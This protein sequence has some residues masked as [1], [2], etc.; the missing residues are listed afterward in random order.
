LKRRASALI[1]P[2]RPT[3]TLW[4]ATRLFIADH[5]QYCPQP[6]VVGDGTLIDLANLIER[7]VSELDAVV[8]IESRPSG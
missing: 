5:R 8:A 7:A 2:R 6:L 1:A 3:A 4:P